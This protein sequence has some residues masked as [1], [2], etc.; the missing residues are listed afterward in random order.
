MTPIRSAIAKA[1]SWSCVTRMVVTPS[2]CWI[3]PDGAPQFLA[4]LG[5]ER[6]ERLVEQE[7]F[8]PVR[9]RAGDGDALLLAAGKLGRQAL[10][11]ALERDE[12]QQLCAPRHALGT[13]HAPDAQRELDVVRDAHVAEERVVLEYE[14]D[15]AVAGRNAG[16]VAPVQRYAPVVDLDEP[17][18]GAQQRALAA[19][20]R[21]EQNEE[22]AL[23]DLERD[24]VDDRMRL[25]PLGDLVECDGHGAFPGPNEGERGQG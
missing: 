21:A 9:E 5:V 11:H 17:G 16:D 18:D 24:V 14:A 7:H 4:D 8:R 13:A 25:I 12:L 2:S 10:V 1:S 3:L 19:A 22:L 20:A 23:L 15:A 6:A